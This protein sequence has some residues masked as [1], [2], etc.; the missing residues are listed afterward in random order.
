MCVVT[1][2]CTHSPNHTRSMMNS[3]SFHLSRP[4]RLSPPGSG[5]GRTDVEPSH[6]QER[7]HS[8][9]HVAQTKRRQHPFLR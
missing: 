5:E 7:V 3:T 4:K 6:C 1:R 9:T 2:A 8:A